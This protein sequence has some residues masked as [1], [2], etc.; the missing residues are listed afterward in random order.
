MLE[1]VARSQQNQILF[2]CGVAPATGRIVL[3]SQG[4]IRCIDDQGLG[5]TGG[6][7]HRWPLAVKAR[8]I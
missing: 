1:G 7:I 8:T 5:T 4:T 3:E 2:A 6:E